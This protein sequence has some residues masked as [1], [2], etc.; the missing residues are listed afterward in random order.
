MAPLETHPLTHALSTHTPLYSHSRD[1]LRV[2]C[3]QLVLG[4]LHHPRP[5]SLELALAIALPTAPRLLLTCT[6]VVAAVELGRAM[7]ANPQQQQQQVCADTAWGCRLLQLSSPAP[8]NSRARCAAL[9]RQ[10]NLQC[11]G[12]SCVPLLLLASAAA[13]PCSCPTPIT[14]WPLTLRL[15]G[16]GR[17]LALRLALADGVGPEGGHLLSIAA[18]RESQTEKEDASQE[19]HGQQQEPGGRSHPH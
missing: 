10:G 9:Q 7:L 11:R 6:S 4:P 14:A 3:E 19:M 15:A 12:P 5:H 13:G 2:H 17:L 16:R 8:A 18:N 1:L